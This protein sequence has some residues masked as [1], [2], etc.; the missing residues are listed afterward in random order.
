MLYRVY[1]TVCVGVAARGYEAHMPQ[2][3]AEPVMVKTAQQ[4][5]TSSWYYLVGLKGP[6]LWYI[7]G[8]QS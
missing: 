2:F 7:I 4:I 6:I 1:G 8:V 5:E 3:P